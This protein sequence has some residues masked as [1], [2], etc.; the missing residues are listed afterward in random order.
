MKYQI[1]KDRRTLAV[2]ADPATIKR[3]LNELAGLGRNIQSD[4]E[5]HNCFEAMLANSELDWINPADT[6]DLTS[7]PMLGILGGEM[8][9]EQIEAA[10][11]SKPGIY[12]STV[13]GHANGKDIHQP[14]LERWAFLDYQLRSPLEDLR[15]NGKAVFIGG[16]NHF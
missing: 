15:D 7:A 11:K 2:S 8:T 16:A 3:H 10:A 4:E 5:L 1:S 9:I 14:I 6:G 13:C 12:G